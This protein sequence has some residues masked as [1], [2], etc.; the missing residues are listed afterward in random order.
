VTDDLRRHLGIGLSP[1][2]DWKCGSLSETEGNPAPGI[3][4]PY[5]YVAATEGPSN[6]TGAVPVAPFALHVEDGLLYSLNYLHKGAEKYWVVVH[7]H[8]S[9][10]LE[11]RLLAESSGGSGGGGGDDAGSA[12]RCSQFLRHKSVWVPLDVLDLWDIRY[13]TVVQK[14]GDLVV[15]AP[16]AYHQGWNGGWNV[17]EA[18]NYGDGASAKRIRGYRHCRLDCPYEG[19]KPLRIEWRDKP[20]A[21]RRPEI[22]GWSVPRPTQALKLG[23]NGKPLDVESTLACQRKLTVHEVRLGAAFF[24]SSQHLLALSFNTRC[25]VSSWRGL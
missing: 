5:L 16:G 3:Q 23:P 2:S 13:T 10:R 9:D 7:P 18:I 20:A 6:S 21:P 8:D 22:H 25:R 24:I 11:R 15:T 19:E 4:T 1:F 12:D 17:A 14:K